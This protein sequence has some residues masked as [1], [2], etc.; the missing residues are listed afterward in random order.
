M[1]KISEDMDLWADVSSLNFDDWMQYEIAK[2]KTKRGKTS[3]ELMMATFA[4]KLL[5]SSKV[6]MLVA[7]SHATS[8][9]GLA[10]NI[11]SNNSRPPVGQNT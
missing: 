3:Y 5:S 9:A 10:K 6:C 8:T 11:L 1:E 7:P 2:T 4:P